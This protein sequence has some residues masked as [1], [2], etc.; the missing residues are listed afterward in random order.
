MNKIIIG[1]C[2]ERL[3]ELESNSVDCVVTSPPYFL[4][5]DYGVDGQ[6]GLEATV[7]DYVNVL[8]DVFDEIKRI[9]KDTGSLYV[10]IG[11]RYATQS[12]TAYW[13]SK[14]KTLDEQRYNGLP[15]RD[16]AVYRKDILYEEG[17]KAAEKCLMKIP[18]MVAIEMIKRGWILRNEIIWDKPNG[19]PFPT[20]D[21][22]VQNFEKIF[23]FVKSPKY[24]HKI[25][26]EPAKTES[27]ERN[28]RDS[29]GVLGNP[30]SGRRVTEK[31]I[32]S[33]TERRKRAIWSIP[34][35]AGRQ[36]HTATFPEDLVSQCLDASCPENG[37]VLDPFAGFGTTGMVAKKRGLDFIL[38]E[39]NP[40]YLNPELTAQSTVTDW[41]ECESTN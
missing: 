37:V 3:K 9:L 25:Q 41:T 23:F 2:L 24:Y 36:K 14:G 17:E 4:Q 18:D 39:L 10:N 21:R 27:W 22:F 11:D 12:G 31:E 13:V 28:I 19:M 16:T 5:R 30:N 38:I 40:E 15:I 20:I 33:K 35:T 34:T 29:R 26:F 1:N 7:S 6:I 8:C 32:V